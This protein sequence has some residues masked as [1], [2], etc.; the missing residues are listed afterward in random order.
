MESS[1]QPMNICPSGCDDVTDEYDYLSDS[2]MESNQ[3]GDNDDAMNGSSS[4]INK[5][6]SR[7]DAPRSLC[8][9]LKYIFWLCIASERGS[10]LG[11]DPPFMVVTPAQGPEGVTESLIVGMSSPL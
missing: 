6:N 9:F 3:D 7:F 4:S 1:I 5:E 11:D 8:K 10:A 2:D